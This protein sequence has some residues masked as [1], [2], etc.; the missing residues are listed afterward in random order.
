MGLL[1]RGSFLKLL[2]ILA[3]LAGLVVAV[4]FFFIREKETP[5]E[6]GGVDKVERITYSEQLS[7]D[8]QGL[9]D[10]TETAEGVAIVSSLKAGETQVDIPPSSKINLSLKIF[11]MDSRYAYPEADWPT[12]FAYEKVDMPLYSE[13]MA[14]LF[15]HPEVDQNLVQYLIW[16]LSSDKKV[17]F[18]DLDEDEQNLLLKINPNARSI[19]DSYEY[20]RN[21]SIKAF[22]FGEKMPEEVVAQPIPGTGLYVKVVGTH[23][24]EALDVEI[25]NPTPAVQTL[26]LLTEEGAFS[27]VPAGWAM[28]VKMEDFSFKLAVGELDI[29]DEIVKTPSDVGAILVSEDGGILILDPGAQL[30]LSELNELLQEAEPY[31]DSTSFFGI[32]KAY[33][34]NRI[35]GKHEGTVRGWLQVQLGR[36]WYLVGDIVGRKEAPPQRTSAAG[37]RG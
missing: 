22:D 23:A 17:K 4:W 7:F 26:P 19:V 34:A 5:T 32:A 24:N 12:V 6:T 2:I 14:Y 29:K 37:V 8:P 9:T 18:A 3:G 28:L 13:V 33:A 36:F 31:G 35:A 25:Y 16:D 11:C 27:T 10:I 20:Y 21:L 1:N 30:T 15:A